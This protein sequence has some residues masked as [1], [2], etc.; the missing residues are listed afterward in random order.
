[1]FT[2]I[3]LRPPAWKIRALVIVG[4]ACAALAFCSIAVGGR[5]ADRGVPAAVS[6]GV[7]ALMSLGHAYRLSGAS[8]RMR[9]F[10]I[11]IERHSTESLFVEWK[12]IESIGAAMFTVPVA[13]RAGYR[14]SLYIGIR[15]VDKCPKRHTKDCEKNRN[16]SAYD[17]LL[18]PIY[19]MSLKETVRRLNEKMREATGAPPPP[20]S[21]GTTVFAQG[22]PPEKISSVIHMG[23]RPIGVMLQPCIRT[24]CP[25]CLS[26]Q[27][28]YLLE[29]PFIDPENRFVKGLV[30]E[31]CNLEVPANNDIERAKLLEAAAIWKTVE[32]KDDARAQILALHSE[33]IER[34]IQGA[35][36][37]VCPKCGE[38]NPANFSECWNC[39][40]IIKDLPPADLSDA[41]ESV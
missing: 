22:L 7:F 3:T 15:L 11:E 14:S 34:I 4:A 30:C 23:G 20:A 38:Q 31:N 18:T 10:G 17:I 6:F 9:E 40:Y 27:V 24:K 39:H 21:F 28:F 13:S 33:V 41:P 12:E 1:M 16:Y 19:G 32:S 36:T 5:R 29:A 2:E 26:E 8:L 25:M 35:E 37:V